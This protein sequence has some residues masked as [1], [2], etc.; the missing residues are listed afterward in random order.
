MPTAFTIR[1]FGWLVAIM[2]VRLHITRRHVLSRCA[3][4]PSAHFAKRPAQRRVCFDVR[5]NCR[6]GKKQE[7]IMR[8]PITGA[9]ALSFKLLI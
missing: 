2:V 6:K 7:K 9:S 4:R 3:P 1:G 5:R 8:I